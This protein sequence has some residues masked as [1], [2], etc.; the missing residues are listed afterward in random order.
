MSNN[1]NAELQ[2]GK[3]VINVINNSTLKWEEK[4]DRITEILNPFVDVK[5]NFDATNEWYLNQ[6][7]VSNLSKVATY[8]GVET[9]YGTGTDVPKSILVKGIVHAFKQGT[10]VPYALYYQGGA[11]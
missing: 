1:N 5:W 9:P 7:P 10:R 3:L 11:F 2:A 8:M 6:L 4:V